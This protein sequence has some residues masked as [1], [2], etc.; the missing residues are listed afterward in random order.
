MKRHI[1][2]DDQ[3]LILNITG[4]EAGWAGV[5]DAGNEWLKEYVTEGPLPRPDGR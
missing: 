5:S 2:A 3:L 4:D 1:G